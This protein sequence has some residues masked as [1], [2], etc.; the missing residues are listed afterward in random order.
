MSIYFLIPSE[1]RVHFLKKQDLSQKDL[2]Q[3]P[4]T[5]KGI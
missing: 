1:T 4:I 3:M 5:K 2:S